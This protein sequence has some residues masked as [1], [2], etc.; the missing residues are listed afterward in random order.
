[1]ILVTLGTQDKKFTRLLDAI[2]QQIDLKNIN[3]DVIV[4]AGF[5]SDYKSKDM[6]VFDLIPIDEFSDLIKKCDIL[7]THGGVGSILT[8]LKNNK[9]IIAMARLKKYGEHT[10][11]HQLQIIEKFSD[12]GYLLAAD[13]TNLAQAL[14]A[15]KG[16]KPKKYKSNTKKMV[17]IIDDFIKNK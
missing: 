5:T 4:Q 2:Q 16:F 17:R 6:K 3:D 12:M 13:E 15:I 10:N 9:K 7:I 1:M 11:D 14:E 8:G